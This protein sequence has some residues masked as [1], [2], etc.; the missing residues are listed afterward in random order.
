MTPLMLANHRWTYIRVELDRLTMTALPDSSTLC[1]SPKNAA[2]RWTSIRWYD[3]IWGNLCLSCLRYQHTETSPLTET[4][5]ENMT[6][7]DPKIWH[8]ETRKY[9]TR[10]PENMTHGDMLSLILGWRS[11]IV[12]RKM[13]LADFPYLVPVKCPLLSV[14]QICQLNLPSL[15]GS[16]N[17]LQIG[18][19]G[20]GCKRQN[21]QNMQ[22]KC[23]H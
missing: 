9:Y 2:T 16:V 7:G 1:S 8:T 23:N 12:V 17:E 11:S 20:R 21:T 3:D 10:R 15:Q 19:F 6:H 22:I 13:A 14:S 18:D 5:S 4:S